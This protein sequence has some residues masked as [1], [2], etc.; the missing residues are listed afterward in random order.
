MT[1]TEPSGFPPEGDSAPRRRG[2]ASRLGGFLR[3]LIEAV[4]LAVVLFFALQYVVQNTVVEGSSMH[5]NFVNREHLLVNKLAYRRSEP[6]RGDV[7]V[8]RSDEPSGKE[9]IKRV[10]GLPGDT[11]ELREGAVYIDGQPLAEPW[12][13]IVDE[14]DFPPYQVPLGHYFVLGDNRANSNDSRVFGTGYG[15]QGFEEHAV[16][17]QLIVGKVW[18]S[19]WPMDTWGIVEAGGQT[20]IQSRQ[21]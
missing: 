15:T 16:P 6:M 10:I 14:S 3:D 8:F 7:V 18:L 9:F 13:P 20:A 17:E 12:L 4:V 1:W 21:P 19:V 2:L 11:V 5:P